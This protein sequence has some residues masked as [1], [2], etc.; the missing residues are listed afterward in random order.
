MVG[1]SDTVVNV[2]LNGSAR[3][4]LDGIPDSYRMPSYRNQLSDKEIAEVLSFVRGSWGN[5]GGEV[6]PDKVKSLRERTNPASSNP[7]ILQMR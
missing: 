4:I 3:V 1:E 2:T 7:I 6:K 5:Q